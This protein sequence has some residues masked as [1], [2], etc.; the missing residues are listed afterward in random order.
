MFSLAKYISFE[1][2]I[3]EFFQVISSH[4]RTHRTLS[5]QN[6]FNKVQKEFSKRTRSIKISRMNIFL[7][8]TACKCGLFWKVTVIWCFGTGNSDGEQNTYSATYCWRVTHTFFLLLPSFVLLKS[9]TTKQ[10]G[11]DMKKKSWKKFKVGQA[12]T[13]TP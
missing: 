4:N 6:S 2:I 13:K 7:P 11:L 8:F 12:M 3:E 10:V 1:K 9:P 5:K